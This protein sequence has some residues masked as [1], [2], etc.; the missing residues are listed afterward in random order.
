M[1]LMILCT[2]LTIPILDLTRIGITALILAKMSE[3]SVE[4]V[5][6]HFYGAK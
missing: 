1:I 6:P 5:F 3:I 2:F 4:S